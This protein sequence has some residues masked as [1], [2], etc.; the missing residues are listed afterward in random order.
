[1][2]RNPAD[3]DAVRINNSNSNYNEANYN[4][5]R[6]LRINNSNTNENNVGQIGR[7]S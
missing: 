6:G 4:G 2:F 1:M 7:E 5:A 3:N